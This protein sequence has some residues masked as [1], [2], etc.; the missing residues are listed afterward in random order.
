[1]PFWLCQTVRRG[2][3]RVAYMTDVPIK[4]MLIED[5]PGDA[6]LIEEIL[7]DVRDF[8]FTLTNE[9]RISTGLSA[10][11]GE[12]YDVILLDLS[13]PDAQG[14]E[15]FEKLKEAVPSIPV[16]VLTGMHDE[17]LAVQA[18]SEGA[19]D[20]L[21][22]GEAEGEML[23][24]ALR[25]A[26][27]RK[28][29]TVNL[30]ETNTKLEQALDELKEAQEQLLQQ[31]R[32]RALNSMASGIAHDFNNA[33]TP[34]L[35]YTELLL[36]NIDTFK[37]DEVK[38][39]LGMVR[40][41][42]K[43]AADTVTRLR[44]FYHRQAEEEGAIPFDLNAVVMQAIQLTQPGWKNIALASG[45]GIRMRQDL[46]EV[47]IMN[48]NPMEMREIITNLILNAVDAMPNGGEITIRTKTGTTE[49]GEPTAVLEIIDTGLGMTP[50]VKDRCLEP[51]FT[52]KE[53]P[54]AG[55]GMSVLYSLI[56][57]HGVDVEI[58]SD[59]D[60]GTRISMIFP[61]R[62]KVELEDGE[63]KDEEPGGVSG[64]EEDAG[65]EAEVKDVPPMKI[66][67]VDDDTTVLTVISAYLEN[68]GHTVVTAENGR[69]GHGK[70]KSMNFDMVI[71][72][73][74]MPGMSGEQLAVNVKAAKP[75]TPV[76]LL[77]GFGDLMKTTGKKPKCIDLIVNKP[78]TLDTMRRVISTAVDTV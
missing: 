11:E 40:E 30:M 61:I 58:E 44:E 32:M 4:V 71:T 34:V 41:G 63:E 52:T 5:N 74:S 37:D 28:R 54:G 19:Q 73:N 60:L 6:R 55:L 43:E 56:Q 21:I 25:Y 75:K 47:P 23:A 33:L 50:E 57:R 77:T 62:A 10:L 68:L 45:I 70:F 27:E 69:E 48:G 64:P 39:F 26:I 59:M 29:A 1:M 13:L 78:V 35:G 8:E 18:V 2:E 65:E 72:D 66:L 42:A 15:G 12:E 46:G 31:E 7:K 20:Y 9:D 14:I 3:T 16:V 51:F 67:L 53:E 17:K 49:E 76:L 24:R 38:D 22:K 36:A